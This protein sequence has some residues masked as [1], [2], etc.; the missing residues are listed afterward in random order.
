MK[1]ALD[2]ETARKCSGFGKHNLVRGQH[3]VTE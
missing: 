1:G 2:R 3:N